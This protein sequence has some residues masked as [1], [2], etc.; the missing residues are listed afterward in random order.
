LGDIG[1]ILS[2][3]ELYQIQDEPDNYIID[4]LVWEN[5][6]II[7]LAKEKV[8]KS[9]LS[10]QMA[11]ALTC[12][13]SLFGEY[14]IPGPMTVLYIQTES[15]RHETIQ[16]LRHMTHTSG[17]SWEPD[18]FHLMHTPS[19]SIDTDAG[20]EWLIHKIQ[21][22]KIHPK[23]IFID[24]LYM[25]MEG[26]LSDNMASRRASKNIRILNEV[27]GCTNIINHHEH[28]PIRNKNSNYI[29]E[30]DNA[31]MG[32]FVWKAFPNHII[33][34][35]MLSDKTRVL[36]CSTQRS[37]RVIENM[38]LK[39]EHPLPLRYTIVGTPDHPSYVSMVENWVTKHG[40]KCA[41]EIHE[42]MGI[43]LSAV[44][45]ALSYLSKQD[46]NK[47]Y[48]LN[49]GSRPTYYNVVVES[50]TSTPQNRV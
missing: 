13:E 35:S 17:E 39:M 27:F 50:N 2:G 20:I 32:S 4:G 26:D 47:L 10:L 9:I 31:V 12:G 22:R 43:S 40:K 44:K 23:V 24:P 8:G 6:N 30:G 41:Q 19:L 46:V 38:K 37:S 16:R 29:V 3:T 7:L 1:E 34:L 49:P 45:K 5:Q 25:C 11:C 15:T 33:H 18:N 42:E 14:E 48:K 36:S 28:R 21:K